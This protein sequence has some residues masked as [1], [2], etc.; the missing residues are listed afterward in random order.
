MKLTKELDGMVATLPSATR[1]MYV[2]GEWKLDAGVVR[3]DAPTWNFRLMVIQGRNREQGD[4][5]G[6]A[7]SVC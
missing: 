5:S 6:D 1:N 7:S 2:D 3:E 4:H